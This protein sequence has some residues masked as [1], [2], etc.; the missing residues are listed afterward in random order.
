MHILLI[1]N[2]GMEKDIKVMVK[3]QRK[4]TIEEVIGLIEEN[5][6]KEAFDLIIRKAEV[7]SYLPPGTKAKVSPKLTLVEDLL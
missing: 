2:K 3:L 4:S 6:T 7:H 1:M 5:K